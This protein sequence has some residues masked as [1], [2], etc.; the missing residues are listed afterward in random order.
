M[1]SK[2]L[3]RA[4]TGV[5][6]ASAAILLATP[7][8]ASASTA[9]SEHG[10]SEHG[11]PKYLKV[12]CVNGERPDATTLGRDGGEDGWSEP[13]S[14]R[15]DRKGSDEY[16][17]HYKSEKQYKKDG[18]NFLVQETTVITCGDVAVSQSAAQDHSASASA[19]GSISLCADVV[20]TARVAQCAEES[21]PVA[22]RGPVAGGDGGASGTNSGLA[23]G[24]SGALAAAAALGTVLLR[25]RS[26]AA[27][28]A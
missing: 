10:D 14:G 19:A 8:L 26:S 9:S 6:A 12:I 7:G 11:G 28:A 21:A 25:R 1:S 18:K 15:E 22:P 5:A 24:G 4:A 27:A 20:P 23:A 17:G 13:G 16:D 2:F 3:V